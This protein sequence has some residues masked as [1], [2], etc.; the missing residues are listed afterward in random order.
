[1]QWF[2]LPGLA[3]LLLYKG[4]WNEQGRRE[5]RGTRDLSQHSSRGEYYSD[6][7][8]HFINTYGLH[9]RLFDSFFVID[10]NQKAGL[11]FNTIISSSK[12][13]TP[14]VKGIAER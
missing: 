14:A 7:A 5:L 3:V 2:L 9:Y 4:Y 12:I 8:L 1:M 13:P 6:S 11:A 10:S